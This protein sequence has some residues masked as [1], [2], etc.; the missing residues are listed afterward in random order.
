MFDERS[1][2][3]RVVQQRNVPGGG[4]NLHLP[5]IENP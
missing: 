5:I 1:S 3:L 2:S 4:R